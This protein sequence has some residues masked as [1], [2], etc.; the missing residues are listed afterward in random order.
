MILGQ[1][2]AK[3][4]DFGKSPMPMV[5]QVPTAIYFLENSHAYDY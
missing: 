5:I 1:K 4:V 2:E 3:K